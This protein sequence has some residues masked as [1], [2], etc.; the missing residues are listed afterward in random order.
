MVPSVYVYLEQLP[1]TANGKVDRRALPAPEVAEREELYL[2]PRTATEEIVA[3]IWSHVLRV[4]RVGVGENF[5][6]LGGHSLLATQVMSRLRKSFGVE[7]ALRELF[8]RPTI[9]GLAQRVDEALRS[10]VGV[11]APPL[12]P[13]ERGAALPLSFAQQRI[14]FLD[15][16]QPHSGFYNIPS[17]LRLRGV[18]DSEALERSLNEIVRR[19]E[20]LR[21]IFPNRDGEPVQIIL[22]D[23]QLRLSVLDLSTLADAERE[24]RLRELVAVEAAQPFALD[25]APLLRASLLQ[26]AAD[27][28]VL[29]L[30]THHIVSD[31]W[32]MGVLVQELTALYDA[33]SQGEKSPLPELSIQYA[34]YAMWQRSWLQGDVL[35]RQLR[36]W[37]DQ[38]EDAPSV[39]ELP[40]DRARPAMQSY[41]GAAQAVV[42]PAELSD[43]LKSLSRREGVTLFMTLL[44]AFDVLLHRYS[45]Q[46]D[47]SV[48]TAIANR[49]RAEVE[50]L[51]G[52]FFN[53]LTL[54]ADLSGDPSFS[55][56]L[57]RTR[58]VSLG[59]YAHQDL[60]FEQ[61]VEAIQPVRDLSRSPLFQVMF[62]L[63]NAPL[64]ATQLSGLSAEL[65]DIDIRTAK[66]DL[67][68]TMSESE[69]GLTASIEYNS[70]L[71]DPETITR[72][73]NHY[74][75]IL[76]CAVADPAQRV[77]A[78]QY[79]SETELQQL[80]F[81]WNDLTLAEQP[82]P[83]LHEAFE[84]QAQ[85]R[86]RAIAVSFENQQLTYRELNERANQLAHHLARLG[87][88]A[89]VPVAICVERS[90]EM[91]IGLLGILKAGGAYLPLDPS[92]PSERLEFMI[93]D[94]Q[95]LVLLTQSHLLSK[96]PERSSHVLCLDADWAAV[97]NESTSNVAASVVAANTAYVIY[98]SGS[99]GQP[100]GVSVN[101]Q[102]VVHL[103]QSLTPQFCF[104]ESDAWTV[105]H[106]SSFDFS[107]WELW[108]PLVQGGKLV[109]VSSEAVRSPELLYQVL[110]EENVTV[111][112][113]T[114][115]AM[116]QLLPVIEEE[117][118]ELN[119]RLIICGGEALPQDLAEEILKLNIPLWNF[120]GP[121]EAT[122][123]TTIN[124]V[125]SGISRSGVIDVGRPIPQMQVYVLDGNARPVPVGVAGELYIGG[126]GLARGYWRRAELTAER[127]VPDG[128]SGQWG[129]RLYRTG[130]LVRW[131]REGE[132]EYLGRLDQ[133]V[134]VRGYRIELGE[135][136]AALG[137]L[138]ELAAAVVA[139]Q[140]SGGAARLVAY[141]VARGDERLAVSAL[142]EQLQQRL[143]E[144]LVPSV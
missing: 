89:E 21:T 136:E 51:I 2:E 27:E 119:L 71:F 52:L 46:P 134:K 79:I 139:V 143:P 115:S 126:E 93:D 26:L 16:L 132:L 19:H 82:P 60:P 129:E 68:L 128:V 37:R 10:G 11:V 28:H 77:S 81:E 88:T 33:Y 118:H 48:G 138:N 141:L 144:Y 36:Y 50:P 113:Q 112:N 64:Q 116:R 110:L 18:L 104:D 62:I 140:T 76:E 74:E 22:N 70:D 20:A 25:R 39:L 106:S 54:R 56:L 86:P 78:M 59:A 137:E 13:V 85:R 102:S 30:T 65:M 55:E 133:Q 69:R 5:F 131:R 122:V 75:A 29:L 90:A 9:A 99:T 49:N 80:L 14:W 121:T 4:E 111:L 23:L 97:A 84:F 135:I 95:P 47:F 96:L 67:I 43:S 107:V 98:T 117:G 125:E 101:H 63:Q 17:A 42:L 92:Y 61:L 130:D 32:S 66:L 7:L 35:E 142:R 6:E 123:W 8:E 108:S 58:E 87:V 100:K 105:F 40:T 3:G 34:D 1:L 124:K 72:V 91:V 12:E 15:Q 38:L 94:A 41:R 53:T 103:I 31:G 127:F 73:F 109:V 120:Y 114:P 44:A 83:C 57:G 24:A 45:G